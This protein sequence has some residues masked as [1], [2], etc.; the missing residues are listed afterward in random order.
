MFN[1]DKARG[2]LEEIL[3]GKEYRVYYESKGLIATWW[4]KAK[5]WIA[6]QL[7]KLFPAID[8]ASKVSGTILIAI[9]V[10]IVF[11]LVLAAFFVIRNT[12]RNRILRKQKPL[13]SRKEMNWTSQRHLEEADKL[14]SLEEYTSS[15]RHLFLALLLSFHEKG[16]LEA[17]IWK[18]NWDYYDE[19]R[20]VDQ[21][22]TEQFFQFAQLFEEV[23]YGER[24][25]GK[26]EYIQF[27]HEIR[28]VLGDLRE[29]NS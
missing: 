28:K 10:L 6:T 3:K 18:T 8:S 23:T 12:R 16:L 29:E 2:D 13:Q 4:D 19:L 7:E 25:V 5:E 17:R 24:T 15:A 14:E 20:K 22:K 9:I 21:F 27:H 26:E 1:A 11:L